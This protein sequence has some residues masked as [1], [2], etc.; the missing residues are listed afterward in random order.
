MVGYAGAEIISI[1]TWNVDQILRVPSDMLDKS[2][3]ISQDDQQSRQLSCESAE[4]ALLS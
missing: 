1:L 2:L 3:A 4:L